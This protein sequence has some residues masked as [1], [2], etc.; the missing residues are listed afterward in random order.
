[1]LCSFLTSRKLNNQ[2]DSSGRALGVT[3][4]EVLGVQ[5]NLIAKDFEAAADALM[6]HHCRKLSQKLD[7][8]LK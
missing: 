4:R 8:T 2:N 6:S 7:F 1:M 5:S 3:A